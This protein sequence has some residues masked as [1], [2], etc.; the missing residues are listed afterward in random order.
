MARP[1]FEGK[2]YRK[3]KSKSNKNKATSVTYYLH[4]VASIMISLC[5]YK[6][7]LS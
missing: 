2:D 3:E 7:T 4:G 1:G 5:K 6:S